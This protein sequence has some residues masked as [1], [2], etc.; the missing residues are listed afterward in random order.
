MNL[1][2]QKDST[3]CQNVKKL[4]EY[5][6]IPHQIE[7]VEEKTFKKGAYQA[8]SILQKAPVLE[9]EN[10]KFLNSYHAIVKFICSKP[11]S[12]LLGKS[13]YQKILLDQ[14]AEMLI[15]IEQRLCATAKM[16]KTNP[17]FLKSEDFMKELEETVK[18]FSIFN[19]ALKFNTFLAGNEVGFTDFLL[20][21]AFREAKIFFSPKPF[22]DL[23]HL[24]RLDKFLEESGF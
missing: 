9:A 23:S 22:T 10:Q 19:K 17:E 13:E 5:F 7:I 20:V 14:Y 3:E 16:A 2:F 12:N 15:P 24:T 8:K 11:D 4:L 18:E 21:F 1:L 6:T